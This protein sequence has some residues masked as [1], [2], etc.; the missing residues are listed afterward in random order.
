MS[1]LLEKA[2]AAPDEAAS[3]RILVAG[4]VSPADA[5]QEAAIMWGRLG[6]D[7]VGDGPWVDH[8]QQWFDSLPA[9]LE[10]E[11]TGR[12][13]A[14][15]IPPNISRE[16]LCFLGIRPVPGGDPNLESDMEFYYTDTGETVP[17][18]PGSDE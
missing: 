7:I 13:G 15:A 3:V 5:E 11:R 12:S 1:P 4:G 16:R 9:M 14:P 18:A 6:G 2:C 17:P 10:N 8:P